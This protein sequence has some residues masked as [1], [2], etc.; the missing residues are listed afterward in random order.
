MPARVPSHG[1]PS[2]SAEARLYSTRRVG[3]PAE[4]PVV[5]HA[6]AARVRR[7][8]AG[9]LVARFRVAA[10]VDP[11]ARGGRTVVGQLAERRQQPPAHEVAAVDF[12]RQLDG[13]RQARD[14]VVPGQ[15]LDRLVVRAAL[16]LVQ[17]LHAPEQLG[18]DP[19][20]RL[21][22]DRRI[23]HL[24]LPLRPAAAVG[25]RSVALDPVA[26]RQVQHLGV[27]LG[28]V[29]PGRLPELGGVEHERVDYDL[30]LQLRHGLEQPRARPGRPAAG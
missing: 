12:F 28:G 26:A 3:R 8:A 9:H 19:R 13:G 21:D 7:P 25:E 15:V 4:R 30:P 17:L 16:L 10:G 23:D 11:V 22:A 24:L 20:I 1:R 14:Q 2:A 6:E 29:H 5:V 27:N 18:Q